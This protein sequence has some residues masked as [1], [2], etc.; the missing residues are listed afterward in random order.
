MKLSLGDRISRI[1][2]LLRRN[3]DAT[4]P[5]SRFALPCKSPPEHHPD[6]GVIADGKLAHFFDAHLYYCGI[7]ADIH[8]Q[9]FGGVLVNYFLNGSF[10][11]HFGA[12]FQRQFENFWW[13][14]CHV[15]RF[16]PVNSLTNRK[17]QLSKT[18]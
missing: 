16:G 15:L 18:E 3:S 17:A 14:L 9:A 12:H 11:R 1:R 5:Y 7:S 10:E 6:V 13:W 4:N 8:G 2:G